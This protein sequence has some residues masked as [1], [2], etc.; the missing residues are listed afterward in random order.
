MQGLIGLSQN[1]FFQIL[2]NLINLAYFVIGLKTFKMSPNGVKMAV[3]FS[4]KLAR[5][6]QWLGAL[7]PNPHTCHHV[8]N[9]KN[10]QNII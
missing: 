7:P 9:I 8:Q 2:L 4:E 10:I 5:I 6:A 3:F 1:K